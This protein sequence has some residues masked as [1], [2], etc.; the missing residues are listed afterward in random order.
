MDSSTLCA[1]RAVP[2]LQQLIR[3]ACV[4]TGDPDS[5][6]ERRSIDYLQRYL[7]DF[8]IE[9]ERFASRPERPNLVARIPGRDP[10][11]PTLAFMGHVDVVPADASQWS[12]DPFGGDLVDGEVWG[13]GAVDMLGMVA[14][15]VAA[16]SVIAEGEKPPGDV[17]LIVVSD[18]EAGGACGAR[19]LLEEH[20]EA[21][22][23]DYMI[24]EVGGMHI[25]TSKGPG[26]TMTVGE[27]GVCWARVRFSGTPGHGSMP[28]RADNAVVKAARAATLL[29]EYGAPV[30]LTPLVREM[31]EAFLPRP[32][33]R[34]CSRFAAGFN[35]ACA[36][37]FKVD[38]GRARF[39]DTAARTSISP[40]ILTGG[41][42]VNIVPDSAEITVDIR[43]LPEQSVEA[44][45][46]MLRSAMGALGDEAQIEFFEF[47]PSNV[48]D[49]NTPLMRA[50]ER[51]VEDV[52][53]G[54]RVVPM[55]LGGVTDGRYW[56]QRGTVVYGFAANAPDLTMDRFSQRIHGV[57][58]RI[59]VACLET[60]LRFLSRLPFELERQAE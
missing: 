57:D 18:E 22:K 58:E 26:I 50:T 31:C 4:N 2:L 33:E 5:G 24:T 19:W 45:Q 36:S 42:K 43:M 7:S 37:L 8:G 60:N 54:T 35:R 15:S 55:F 47:Y 46:H 25:A 23:C 9:S 13:R 14:S 20:P 34:I 40:N 27:K 10:L 59:S 11:H 53:P 3:N 51:I 6:E 44:I 29:S 16:M 32:W 17:L 38:P 56:R 28:Y 49:R 48:S 12:R 21:A 30:R 41:S 52:L 39:L 1:E